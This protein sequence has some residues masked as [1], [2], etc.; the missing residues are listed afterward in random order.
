MNSIKAD[1]REREKDDNIETL[2]AFIKEA[3][4]LVEK[5]IYHV[6][7]R[8]GLRA[9]LAG[10]QQMRKSTFNDYPQIPLRL[11]DIF[12]EELDDWRAGLIAYEKDQL[13]LRLRGDGKG[14]GRDRLECFQVCEE[15]TENRYSKIEKKEDRV[16]EKYINKTQ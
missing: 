12:K 15:K 11:L 8:E 16:L 3:Y 13:G 14:T 10:S 1:K 2:I 4:S 5:S 9:T 7:G 6:E